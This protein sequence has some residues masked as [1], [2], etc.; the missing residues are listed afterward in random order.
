MN[1]AFPKHPR[2]AVS[3]LLAR[4]RTGRPTSY[5]MVQRANPPR[6][7]QWSPPGG[8]VELGIT[9][10]EQAQTEVEEE[11]GLNRDQIQWCPRPVDCR[12]VIV[13]DNDRVQFHYTVSQMY[14]ELLGNDT[15][16]TAGDDA[17]AAQWW[18]KEG[19][20]FS[21]VQGMPESIQRWTKLIQA[22]DDDMFPLHTPELPCPVP[23][24]RM[25]EIKRKI[26]GSEQSFELELWSK[27]PATNDDGGDGDR[28]HETIVGR[29]VAP[30]GGKYGMKEGDYSWGVW[31]R[32][33]FDEMGFSAYRMHGRDGHIKGYRFD[34]C[35]VGV[36]LSSS[37]EE[38]HVMAFDDLLLD[39]L[40]ARDQRT[41]DLVLSME[42]EEEVEL[43]QSLLCDTQREVINNARAVLHDTDR[44][45][46]LVGRV[47]DAVSTVVGSRRC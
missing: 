9:Q 38:E 47:D 41:G 8:A 5:A 6:Q 11:L 30:A 22:H 17:A 15:T 34:V 7:H 19:A 2:S 28:R 3:V 16:L 23:P 36:E 4:R 25:K 10:L 42:D 26:N 44:L 33:V 21:L 24:L 12:D 20:E 1:R 35:S 18:T 13:K 27:W 40:V 46:D 32:G 45:I 31:G 37:T 43:Y 39:G 29:W 14:G